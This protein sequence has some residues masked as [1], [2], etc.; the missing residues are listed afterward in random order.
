MVC[1]VRE[2]FSVFRRRV[3]L[4]R[5]WYSYSLNIQSL[6]RPQ[7]EVMSETELSS[8]NREAEPKTQKAG[9]EVLLAFIQ[10]GSRP[11][12][13]L[14]IGLLLIIWLF[15]VREPLFGLLENA[16]LKYGLFEVK[17]L[18][19]ASSANLSTRLRALENLNEQQLQLFLI[20][21]KKREHI[22][23]IGEEVTEENLKKLQEAGLLKQVEKTET[24]FWWEVSEDGKKLHDII[25]SLIISSIR[26]SAEA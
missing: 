21:G 12:A 13:I 23:Y 25:R 6:V 16:Q 19:K 26:R 3:V 14:F 1:D 24:G 8:S 9:N 4:N 7:E 15:T 11:V 17:L 20:I 5:F 2:C 22:S 10:Y 18:K